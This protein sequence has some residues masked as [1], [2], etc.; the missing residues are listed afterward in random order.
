M[1]Q[2]ES[3]LD[4]SEKVSCPKCNFT[5]KARVQVGGRGTGSAVY[6]VGRDS[7]KERAGIDA[8]SNASAEGERLIR[9]SKCPKCGHRRAGPVSFSGLALGFLAGFLVC[10]LV[11]GLAEAIHLPKVGALGC[12]VGPAV[13][14]WVARYKRRAELAQADAHV[15]CEY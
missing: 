2:R 11:S 8:F 9:L 12:L 5:W 15:V 7:A 6:G 4:W 1:Y 10:G 14:I 13:M 3:A